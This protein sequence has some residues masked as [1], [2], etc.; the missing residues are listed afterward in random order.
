MTR[1]LNVMKMKRDTSPYQLPVVEHGSIAEF[2]QTSVTT[3]IHSISYGDGY[4][5]LLIED[6]GFATTMVMFHAAVLRSFESVPMFVGRKVTES[7]EANV[8]F[9][10]DPTLEF[11]I[12][13]GWFGGDWNRPLQQDLPGVLRHVLDGL[14]SHEH[15]IFFGPSGGGFAALYFSTFFPASLAIPMNP[16]TDI[17]LYGASAVVPYAEAAWGTEDI[18]ETDF[19]SNITPMYRDPLHHHVAYIQNLGD[20]SHVSKYLA[21]VLRALPEESRQRFGLKIGR[22]GKGHKPAPGKVLVPLF[23]DAIAAQGQ[24]EK[25]F[26]SQQLETSVDVDGLVAASEQYY[27][28]AMNNNK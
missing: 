19:C 12:N 3:G 24:W 22:W 8:V 5:D 4:L 9:V 28:E 1:K 11:G 13:L 17:S 6:R 7:L 25:L 26:S 23:R 15:T 16:Q 10:S 21:P 20:F 27:E 2:S 14:G 18:T